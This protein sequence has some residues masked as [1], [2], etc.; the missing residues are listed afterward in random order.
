MKL[1]RKIFIIVLVT[2][3]LFLILGTIYWVSTYRIRTLNRYWGTQLPYSVDLIGF[4]SSSAMSEGFGYYLIDLNGYDLADEYIF[5]I[6]QDD[7]IDIQENYESIIKMRGITDTSEI[8][9]DSDIEWTSKKSSLGRLLVI[10]YDDG[11][12]AVIIKEKEIYSEFK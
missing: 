4:D 2:L 5:D 6:E 7:N 10:V 8:D 12:K 1:R 11:E 9:W 3:Q